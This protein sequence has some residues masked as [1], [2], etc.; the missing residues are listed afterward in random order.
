MK[1]FTIQSQKPLFKDLF[2]KALIVFQARYFVSTYH[3]HQF[4][5]YHTRYVSSVCMYSFFPIYM[6][7]FYFH[8]KWT[9]FSF[10]HFILSFHTWKLITLTSLFQKNLCYSDP[11]MLSDTFL[12]KNFVQLIRLSCWCFCFNGSWELVTFWNVIAF[13]FR[14]IICFAFYFSVLT[15]NVGSISMLF[16]F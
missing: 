3:C 10:Y 5:V 12:E 11:W 16:S 8:K 2:R 15:I 1:S 9:C 7:L 6:N 4:L 14:N 13:I